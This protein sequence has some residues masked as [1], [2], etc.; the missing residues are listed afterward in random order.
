[1]APVFAHK[2][3]LLKSFTTLTD[4]GGI[5][6]VFEP[7]GA[8]VARSP[9]AMAIYFAEDIDESLLRSAQERQIG[10]EIDLTARAATG[11]NLFGSGMRSPTPW[12]SF[13]FPLAATLGFLLKYLPNVRVSAIR[14]ALSRIVRGP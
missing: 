2:A 8:G 10:I 3:I 9:T 1:M 5:A 14:T 4:T 11:R 12:L 7:T 13:S 6:P